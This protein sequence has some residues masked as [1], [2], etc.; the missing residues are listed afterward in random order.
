MWLVL[1]AG[2]LLNVGFALFFGTKHLAS[3]V[4]MAGILSAVMFLSLFVIININYPF[5]GGLR[6]S[7]EPLQYT[8][9]NLSTQD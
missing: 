2:A 1:F 7:L 3:Q 9:D 4:I 6:V 5:S 8:L